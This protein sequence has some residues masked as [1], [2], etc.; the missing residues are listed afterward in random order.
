[1]PKSPNSLAKISL[2]CTPV[3]YYS[4]QYMNI[5]AVFNIGRSDL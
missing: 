2:G 5:L 4:V 3:S 1:M